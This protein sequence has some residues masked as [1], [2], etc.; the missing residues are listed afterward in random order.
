M[1]IFHTN[2]RATQHLD[3]DNYVFQRCL[4]AYECAAEYLNGEVLELGT[5]EGY[6]AKHLLTN[7]RN[8]IG[9]DRRRPLPDVHFHER[10]TF[11]HRSIPPLP[12]ITDG[13]MDAVVA[14]HFIEHIQ[15]DETLIGEIHR[16]LKPGGRFICATP[17]RVR[18][19]SRNPWHVREYDANQLEL[20][21]SNYFPTIEIYGIIATGAAASYA[22]RNEKQ[23]KQLKRMDLLNLEQRLPLS[24]L[25]PAYQILNR[26]NRSFL[27]WSRRKETRKI[28]TS[29]FKLSPPDQQSLDLFAIMYK[30]D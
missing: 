2:E 17:N 14:I 22:S 11:V 7:A 23:V 1:R 27:F 26:I 12:D 18:S 8:L 9:I 30:G 25:R 15:D 3:S 10:F 29:D 28:T 21:S 13:Q 5:G 24:L 20:L 19:L 4:F 6:G 16:V